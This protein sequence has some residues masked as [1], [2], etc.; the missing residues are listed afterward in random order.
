ME[1]VAVNGGRRLT[2]VDE[3]LPQKLLRVRIQDV[4]R[5]LDW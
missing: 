2:D 1:T 5:V 4:V 3:G